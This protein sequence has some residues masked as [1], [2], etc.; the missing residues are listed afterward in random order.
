MQ[1]IQRMKQLGFKDTF[2]KII[3]FD[4]VYT[5]LYRSCTDNDLPVFEGMQ[6]AYKRFHDDRN[7]WYAD[8]ILYVQNG[9]PVIFMEAYIYQKQ[10]GC[11][12]C[13]VLD[14]NG[15]FSA[16]QVIL[17]ENYHMSFPYVFEW[18]DR[19][20]M[21]PETSENYSINIYECID[22]PY[23]WEKVSEITVTEQL[24]DSILVEK[25]EKRLT[26]LAS[27]PDSR[28]PLKTRFQKYYLSHGAN[29][30]MFTPDSEYNA[31]QNFQYDQRNAGPLFFHNSCLL[32]P[33]QISTE[34]DYGKKVAIYQLDTQ[35]INVSD[36]NKL[37]EITLQNVLMN[38]LT[39]KSCIGI[40]TYGKTKEFEILDIRYLKYK[41]LKWFYRFG[42]WLRRRAKNE[43][44]NKIA[45]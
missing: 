2:K 36:R 5:I 28:N 44:E 42:K 13:S 4:E 21:I 23:K 41:P 26:L 18:Q 22:F 25:T 39:V 12:A 7:F 6:Y 24:V 40:H 45:P 16:P 30:F 33:V 20:Y 1:G 11:I 3:G 43:N 27:Q 17:E 9:Q 38:N 29:T 32:H 8:P 15:S 19:L 10:K 34:K 14:D 37:G 31:K 35:N